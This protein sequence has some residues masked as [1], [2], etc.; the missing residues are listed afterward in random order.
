M[1]KKMIVTLLTGIMVM[2]MST[3]VFAEESIQESSSPSTISKNTSNTIVLNDEGLIDE[4]ENFKSFES[5]IQARFGIELK[6]SELRGQYYYG[7]T[8]FLVDSIEGPMSV[9][10]VIEFEDSVSG[11]VNTSA[12]VSVGVDSSNVEASFGV[13]VSATKTV[14]KTYTFDPIPSGKWLT[15]EAYVNYSV[16]DYDIYLWGEYKG[17][18]AYWIP[19]GIVV[20]QDLS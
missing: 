5:D 10:P 2:G 11:G 20:K 16:Y 9:G 17:T 6:N 3:S 19:V 18:G 8:P 4:L 15:Y 1:F 13:D 14:T 12:G 7:D